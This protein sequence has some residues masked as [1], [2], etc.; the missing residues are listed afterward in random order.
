VAKA[1]KDYIHPDNLIVMAV[2]DRAKIEPGLE[3]LNL[4]PIE[5]RNES[6]DLVPAAPVAAAPAVV[7]KQ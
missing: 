2:G 6:G 4:G 3:K 7:E 5:L 1:A